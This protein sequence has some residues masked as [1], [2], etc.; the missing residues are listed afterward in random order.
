MSGGGSSG[1]GGG[2]GKMVGLSG[3]PETFFEILGLR[4]LTRDRLSINIGPPMQR[5]AVRQKR[6][7]QAIFG[8][9]TEGAGC[10]FDMLSEKERRRKKKAKKGLDFGCAFGYS[11][12]LPDESRADFLSPMFFEN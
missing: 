5:R 9:P 10:I 11:R 4:L 12:F 1:I 8:L 6:I 3:L 2:A 7:G